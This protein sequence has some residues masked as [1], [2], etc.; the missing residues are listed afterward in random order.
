MLFHNPASTLWKPLSLVIV[1][2]QVALFQCFQDLRGK[3][4]LKP[5]NGSIY[6]DRLLGRFAVE[7][8]TKPFYCQSF[9]WSLLEK[10]TFSFI[11][12][13]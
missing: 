8:K 7:N 1:K 9:S 6:S 2:L 4:R 12:S 10:R 5:V 13:V 11:G 3:S